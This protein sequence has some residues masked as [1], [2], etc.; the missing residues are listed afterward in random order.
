[1]TESVL[2]EFEGP[3]SLTQTQQVTEFGSYIK[4][5]EKFIKTVINPVVY[6]YKTLNVKKNKSMCYQGTGYLVRMHFS[7]VNQLF[8]YGQYSK[9]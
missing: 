7:F 6:L 4:K 8:L 1:M 9:V 5:T 2:Y 3:W